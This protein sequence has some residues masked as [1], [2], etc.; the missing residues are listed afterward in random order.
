[1]PMTLKEFGAFFEKD[2]AGNL[3]LVKTAKIPRQ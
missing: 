2:V 1:M 3:E